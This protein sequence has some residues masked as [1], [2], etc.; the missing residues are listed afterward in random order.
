MAAIAL[1]GAL[2]CEQ[3]AACEGK[4]TVLARWLLEG[5]ANARALHDIVAGS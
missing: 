2:L 1:A 5:S 4:K 3:A